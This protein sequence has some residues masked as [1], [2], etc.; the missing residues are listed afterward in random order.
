MPHEARLLAALGRQTGAS[1]DFD[2]N[3]GLGL[4]PERNLRAAA[5]L[6][7][8]WERGG[9]AQLVLTKRAS[10]LKHHPGQIAFPG[11]KVEDSD[12]GPEAAA[13]REAQEETGLD[14]A[15]VRVLGTLA[16]HQ[17][18]TGFLVTPVVARIHAAFDPRP[19]PSE[20]EE[21]FA[22][23]LSHVLDREQYRVEGR[24]W[25]GQLRR[26]YTVPWGPHYIWGATAR[27]LYGLAQRVAG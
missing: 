2:L 27:I 10:H 3:L 9:V 11:G 8:I 4:P 1:S 19:D 15:S 26:Y 13:L 17:T 16:P 7:A 12:S 23:P 21:V 5:V 6:V 22:V 24:Q 18:V 14:P 25:R 20:V